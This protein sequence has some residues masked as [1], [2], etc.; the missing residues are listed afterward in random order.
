MR[1]SEKMRVYMYAQNHANVHA[2]AVYSAMQTEKGQKAKGELHV[3]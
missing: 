1:V 2:I 3:C